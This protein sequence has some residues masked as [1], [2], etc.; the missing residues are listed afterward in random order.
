M[1]LSVTHVAPRI[2]GTCFGVF[3]KDGRY[4]NAPS[5]TPAENHNNDLSKPKRPRRAPA[6]LIAPGRAPG[7]GRRTYGCPVTRSTEATTR[8]VGQ[9]VRCCRFFQRNRPAPRFC[10]PPP[11]A[12]ICSCILV[13]RSNEAAAGGAS[14]CAR[15]RLTQLTSSGTDPA[16]LSADRPAPRDLGN[17]TRPRASELRGCLLPS[18]F[19]KFYKILH[20][21]ESLDACMEY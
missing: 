7:P 4:I 13:E 14:T 17:V 3:R 8:T 15:V 12:C 9:P 1:S 20:H 11:S 10:L 6:C 2:S 18:K 19:Q 21:I 16:A 5:S